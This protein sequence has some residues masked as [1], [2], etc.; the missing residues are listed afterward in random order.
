MPGENT[1]DF[2]KKKNNWKIYKTYWMS[3]TAEQT[4]HHNRDR[5]SRMNPHISAPCSVIC[6]KLPPVGFGTFNLKGDNQKT[7]CDFGFQQLPI[8]SVTMMGDSAIVGEGKR[9]SSL[10]SRQF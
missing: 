4:H 10:L 9:F 3:S 6:G 8:K 1:P 5:T 2:L 7:G